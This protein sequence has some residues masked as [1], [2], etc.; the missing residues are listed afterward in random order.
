LACHLKGI[1][2]FRAFFGSRRWWAWAWLGSAL[3]LLG[4]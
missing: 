1:T 4:T 2:M 3:I